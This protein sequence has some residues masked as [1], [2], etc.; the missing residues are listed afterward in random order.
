MLQPPRPRGAAAWTL[1]GGSM[2][3]RRESRSASGQQGDKKSVSRLSGDTERGSW[4]WE[5]SGGG[6]REEEC[7]TDWLQ[8]AA[9]WYPATRRQPWTCCLKSHASDFDCRIVEIRRVRGGRGR[10]SA[11]LRDAWRLSPDSLE[12][13]SVPTSPSRPS[14][15]LPTPGQMS[16][17]SKWVTRVPGAAVFQRL[18][19][20][21]FQ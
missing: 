5:G 8:A 7:G 10:R 18:H 16:P 20:C 9:E 1:W 2:S 15:F 4:G 11:E 17:S 14:Q 3:T 6:N 21:S 13:A 19:A 12:A